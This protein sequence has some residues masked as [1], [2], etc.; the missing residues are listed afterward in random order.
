MHRVE[1]LPICGFRD[2][3]SLHTLISLL[4]HPY[5]FWH[6]NKTKQNKTKNKKTKQNKTKSHKIPWVSD[7]LDDCI[8]LNWKLS[9]NYTSEKLLEVSYTN[10]HISISRR[11]SKNLILVPNYSWK[12]ILCSDTKNLLCPKCHLFPV[13]CECVTFDPW[14][15][16]LKLFRMLHLILI[17]SIQHISPWWLTQ[18]KFCKLEKHTF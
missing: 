14:Q 13:L 3:W 2:V 4:S 8:A 10:H 6:I 1:K 12:Y 15:I 16:Y 5:K 9:Q 18:V 17:F 7:F 11:R